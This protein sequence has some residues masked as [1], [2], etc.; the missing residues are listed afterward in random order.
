MYTSANQS[1]NLADATGP[2]MD[3]PISDY[4]PPPSA[5]SEERLEAQ[6]S[7]NQAGLLARL[8]HGS[9][10]TLA[11]TVLAQG[12][13]LATT[14]LV[15]RLIGKAAF[16]QFGMIQSTALTLA[17]IA[18]AGFGVT[19]TRYVSLYRSTDPARAGRVLG[20]L[21]ITAA[22][23]GSLFSIA[24]LSLSPFIAS[25]A[26]NSP[27]LSI[28]LSLGSPYVVFVTLNGFQLGALAGLEA[29]KESAFVA[30]VQAVF[31]TTSLLLCARHWGLNGAVAALSISG[32]FAYLLNNRVLA[33]CG[34]RHGLLIT[35]K[36]AWKERSAFS[37][38]G[39]PAGIAGIV[40]NIAIWS[41]YAITVNTVAGFKELG[42][43]SAANYLR[44]MI[45][46]VPSIVTRVALP[47]NCNRHGE[48]QHVKSMIYRQFQFTIVF[49]VLVGLA[50]IISAPYV[51]K[52]FG[53][54]F[55]GDNI[56][57]ILFSCAAVLEVAS[58]N[59]AQVLVI[60]KKLWYQVL[61]IMMWSVA[62][63]SV[64]YILMRFFRPSLAVG[65]GY[66][67][68][69]TI[70]VILYAVWARKLLR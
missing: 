20:M 55:K 3:L 66:V 70:S 35:Y 34:V 40:G 23:T 39:L 25:H 64:S 16:G 27:A 29:F 61:A 48:G 56:I 65:F 19:A 28:T 6:S 47:I 60:F 49:A 59:L 17:G 53:K 51:L 33:K 14:V 22:C 32:V 43:I 5:G 63:F 7:R 41:C 46:F 4:R 38:F 44:Q 69:W 18:G 62:L 54:E 2:G 1:S 15:A 21:T 24:L 57:V 31:S 10:W 45:L 36:G 68:A 9:G 58:A 52:L 30:V 12:I 50:M 67:T 11:G 42:A 26:F 8:L 13:A 37:S